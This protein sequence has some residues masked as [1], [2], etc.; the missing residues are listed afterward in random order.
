MAWSESEHDEVV[1]ALAVVCEVTGANYSSAAQSFLL[2]E[3]EQY[4]AL[5]VLS[6]LRR[7]AREVTHKLALAHVIERIEEEREKAAANRRAANSIEETQNRIRALRENVPWELARI[8]GVDAV[9]KMLTGEIEPE[10]LEKEAERQRSIAKARH[11]SETDH[12]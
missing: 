4:S 2:R 1:K 5:E 7:C 9:K 10:D 12:D 8:H 3:L 11:W 6:A